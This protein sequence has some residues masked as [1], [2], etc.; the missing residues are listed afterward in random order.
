MAILNFAIHAVFWAL[1]FFFLLRIPRCQA[2]NIEGKSSYPSVSIIIPARNEGKTLPILMA[3]IRDQ[4]FTPVE[5]IVVVNQ[6]EDKTIEAAEKGGAIV[7][8]SEP[9]P[10]GWLGKTWSCYQGAKAAKGEIFIFLDA[11][12][13]LQKDGLKA[14]LDEY[15]QR[16][17]VLSLQPY[18]QTKRLYEQLSAFF[19]IIAMWAMG[20]F[21]IAGSYTKP[22]GVF[23][24]CLVIRK[25]TYWNTGG[26]REVK[27]EVVEDLALGE[28]FKQK[29]IPIYCYG[30]VGAIS[31]RMYP[32]GI[33]DLI[34]GWTKGFA[35]GATKTSLPMLLAIIAWIGGGIGAI[36]YLIEA[37]FNIN[38]FLILL[39][40]SLYIFYVVQ[41]YWMM[42]RLGTFKLYTAILYPVSLI[43][44][45][46]VFSY[47]AYRIFFRKSVNWKGSTLSLKDRGTD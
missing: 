6:S 35:K 25:E 9:M 12:T 21:T 13:F 37:I 40:A 41:I 27:G 43:F 1:G 2:N 34:S 4:S 33:G 45:L 19:N 10:E 26:H 46:A 3:S 38:T 15:L 18:H 11:D 47:S 8:Q 29:N 22:L 17:G 16:N 30:G 42:I 20:A 5:I 24:P 31:F 39:W 23:G 14:I 7:I 36:I 44:F 32:N 28:K